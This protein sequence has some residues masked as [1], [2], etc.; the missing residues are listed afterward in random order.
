MFANKRC[1]VVVTGASRGLGRSIS[2]SLAEQ[3][4]D[5]SAFLLLSRTLKDLEETKQN[6]M[7]NFC[8]KKLQ[9]TVACVDNSSADR[10]MYE[11]CLNSALGED[12]SKR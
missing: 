10:E 6:L 8:S 4:G 12:G 7:E 3:V 9:V 2:I 11:S 1:F 5:E